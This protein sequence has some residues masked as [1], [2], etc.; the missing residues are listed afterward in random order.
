MED[1]SSRE[2]KPF[3]RRHHP[4][5][6]SISWKPSLPIFAA[7]AAIIQTSHASRIKITVVNEYL[8]CA[9]I[10]Q[11]DDIQHIA[12]WPRLRPNLLRMWERNILPFEYR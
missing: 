2:R 1:R 10:I 9:T 4:G 8:F 6:F 12:V 11:I 7:E 3:E 5:P